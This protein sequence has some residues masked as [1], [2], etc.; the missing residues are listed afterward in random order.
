MT[1]DFGI[2]GVDEV[3]ATLDRAVK[4]IEE[5]AA[6]AL[7]AQGDALV[8]DVIDGTPKVSG[9]AAG[10][11]KKSKATA[12]EVEVAAGGA[13][14][15]YFPIIEWGGT[16]NRRPAAP[17]RKGLEKRRLGLVPEMARDIKAGVPELKD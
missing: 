14:A 3:L 5:E 17:F 11:V 7:E 13:D 12:T 1:T 9:A 4:H 16:H 2:H 6:K 10:T 15:P 8:S